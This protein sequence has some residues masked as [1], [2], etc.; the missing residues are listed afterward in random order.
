MNALGLSI[1][2]SLVPITIEGVVSLLIS[3]TIIFVSIVLSDAIIAHEMEAKEV[4]VMS[5]F[6][7]FLTPLAQSLLARYIPFVGFILVPLF[8]WFVLGEIFLRKDST[9]NMKVAILAFVIYQILIYSGIVSRV[10]GLV[11]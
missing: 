5:F 4:L 6:A 7:Y 2:F 8:V 9:T 3:T 11:L 10:A 1:L